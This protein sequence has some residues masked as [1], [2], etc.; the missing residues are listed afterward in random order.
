MKWIGITG[1][2]RLT[3]SKVEQDVRTAVREIIGRGDGIVSG[4]AVNVDYFATDE[5][6]KSGA[7]GSQL[8][9]II[10]SDLETYAAHYR[11]RASE[12]AISKNQ[13]EQ[14]IVQLTMVKQRDGLEEMNHTEMNT[15]TYYDRN[16]SVVEASDEMLGFQVNESKGVQDTID[17]AEATGK[18]VSLRKYSV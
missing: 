16:T 9:I 18:K 7:T 11:N 10:P 4:G 14:L 8:H 13:A 5:A 12:G 3:S 15:G 1:S 17:K 2:W 6:L